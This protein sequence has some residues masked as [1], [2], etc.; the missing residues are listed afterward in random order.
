MLDITEA[1]PLSLANLSQFREH[2][3]GGLEPT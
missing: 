2:L 3:R 1:Q